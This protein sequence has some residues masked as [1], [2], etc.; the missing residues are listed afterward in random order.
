MTN[1]LSH[2][3]RKPCI[4]S[5]PHSIHFWEVPFLDGYVPYFCPGISK[6]EVDFLDMVEQFYGKDF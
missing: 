1:T 6:H 5:V 3:I 4:L 2:I